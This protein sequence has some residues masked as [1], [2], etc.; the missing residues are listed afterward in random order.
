MGMGM[1]LE[2]ELEIEIKTEMGMEK[3]EWKLGMGNGKWEWEWKIEMG[4]EW[5]GMKRDGT[6]RNGTE[7]NGMER[8]GTEWSV[9]PDLLP[10]DVHRDGRAR[11]VRE[12]A[13]AAVEQVLRDDAFG[14]TRYTLTLECGSGGDD[15]IMCDNTA[16]YLQKRTDLRRVR[17]DRE[18][19]VS[20]FIL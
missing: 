9:P 20:P 3:W 8:N 17:R 10:A 4:M 5:N 13:R 19:T 15:S 12:D 2:M 16:I 6:E 18:P 11:H 14:K 7:W 1:G